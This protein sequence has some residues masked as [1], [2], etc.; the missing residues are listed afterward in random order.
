MAKIKPFHIVLLA[1]ALRIS[2]VMFTPPRPVEWDDAGS[3]DAVAWNIKSGKGFLESDGTPTTQRPPVYPMILALI[4]SVAGHN[5]TA[6]KIFQCFA[7]AFTVLF[8]F[9]ISS[10]IFSIEISIISSI[11]VALYPPLIVY[12]GIIGAEIIFTFTLALA[13]YFLIKAEME[14]E[15]TCWLLAGLFFGINAM[16]RS[17][18]IFFPL[19]YSVVRFFVVGEKGLS[20]SFAFVLVFIIT[21][22]PWSFRN[23]KTCGTFTPLAA[24]AGGLFWASTVADF[25]GMPAPAPMGR[26][27]KEVK[28]RT[29]QEQD[30]FAYSVAIRNV[31]SNP[32]FYLK[33]VARRFLFVVSEPVGKNLASRKFPSV[34]FV[35]SM[36][37]A[38]M[39]MVAFWGIYR[40]VKNGDWIKS[41]P[42]VVLV[43]Y[44]MVVNSLIASVPRYRLP[45]EPFVLCFAVYGVSEFFKKKI[46]DKMI[47][48]PS[49]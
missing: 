34:G 44:F 15:F 39:T 2:Y 30:V 49:R 17:N 27:Y 45:V 40:V 46:T 26:Y 11:L 16:T 22:L 19:L 35:M 8:I 24:G 41:L 10:K 28:D 4:Y 6:A 31:F 3:W 37:Y 36:L 13:I 25:S 48:S 23:Y 9:L 12:N 47:S 29:F 43:I 1:L 18:A 5:Q 21:L 20:R 42:I 32:L 14:N 7:D 38:I 33:M